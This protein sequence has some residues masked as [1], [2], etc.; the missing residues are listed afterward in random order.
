MLLLLFGGEYQRTIKYQRKLW[1]RAEFRHHCSSEPGSPWVE[2]IPL[3]SFISGCATLK[4]SGKAPIMGLPG[5][6]FP[7]TFF[8][9]LTLAQGR[10][11]ISYKPQRGWK[12]KPK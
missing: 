6:G 9:D 7:G 1:G 8:I 11:S 4:V 3:W 5:E 10:G 12:P 2:E